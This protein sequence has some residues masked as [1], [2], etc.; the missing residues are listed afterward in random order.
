LRI[1]LRNPRDEKNARLGLVPSVQ[2]HILNR[3]RRRRGMKVGN[4]GI[5]VT[6][7][8]LTEAEV[9]G[10]IALIGI[11]AKVILGGVPTGEQATVDQVWASLR[12]KAVTAAER[13]EDA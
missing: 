5:Q 2:N 12:N 1:Y 6:K 10:I 9:L 13:F 8:W 3:R 11:Q 4:N 7:L